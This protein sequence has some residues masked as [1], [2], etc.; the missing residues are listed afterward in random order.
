M[1]DDEVQ[2]AVVERDLI[3]LPGVDG[4]EGADPNGCPFADVDLGGV[5]Q[6]QRRER[7]GPGDRRCIVRNDQSR[8]DRFR[9]AVDRIL[10]GPADAREDFVARGSAREDA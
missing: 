2:R 1:A 10:H 4:V 9:P 5:G 7:L 6:R 3:L 8:V